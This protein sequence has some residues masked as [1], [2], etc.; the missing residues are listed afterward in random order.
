ML[1]R[2]LVGAAL[3]GTRSYAVAPAA[4]AAKFD[5]TA[6]LELATSDE[7]KREVG[8]LK[9]SLEDMDEALAAAGKA[10][11]PRSCRRRRGPAG[12]VGCMPLRRERRTLSRSRCPL[13]GAGC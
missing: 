3:K 4:A 10:R 1:A 11:T 2:A 5:F 13:I 8:V 12:R 7:T 6:A 9:K